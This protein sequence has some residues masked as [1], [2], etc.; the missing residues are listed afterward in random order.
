MSESTLPDALP[1]P[2]EV[3]PEETAGEDRIS[4]PFDPTK[5]KVSVNFMTIDLLLKRVR[6]GE[7]DLAPDFQRKA[8]IWTPRQASRLIESILIRIPLP[9]FYMDATDESRWVVVDGLQRLTVLTRFVVE[10]TMRLQGLEFLSQF[11]GMGYSDLPRAFQRRIDET[12]VTVY[13]I[14]PPT[15]PEA[16]FNIFKRI[17]TGGMPLTAQE[18]RHALNPGPVIGFLKELAESDAFLSATNGGVSP[19]RMDDRECVLRFCAFWLH[20]YEKYTVKEFDSFLNEAMV[21]I[22]RMTSA[23]RQELGDRFRTAMVRARAVFDRHA[24]RKRNPD[25]FNRLLPINK[26]L[27]EAWSVNL[28]CLDSAQ[29]ELLVNRRDQLNSRFISLLAEPDFAAAIS[30]GTGDVR[31]VWTRFGRIEGLIRE[32]LA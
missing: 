29:A 13:T 28:G 7:I 23:Q 20:P 26:A 3:E 18:V 11:E 16:R 19:E 24:F 5:I 25:D 2:A 6:A 15:P 27:F 30:V 12:Q 31:K 22:N 9:A 32:V 17:N 1:E 14:E 8:G 10:Q 4:S 21:E